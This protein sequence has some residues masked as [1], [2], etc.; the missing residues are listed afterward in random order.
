MKRFF[1]LVSLLLPLSLRAQQAYVGYPS[2][3]GAI[4]IRA[5]FANPPKGYG[6]VPF[7]WWSGDTLRLDRLR[8]ELDILADSPT[9]GFAVSYNHTHAKV[10]TAL[11]ASGYGSCG[12]PEAGKPEAFSEGWW[13]IWNEFSGLCADKGM[14]VGMDD[15]V[16]AWPKNKCYIDDVLSDPELKNYQGK[17][18]KAVLPAGADLP[19]NLVTASAAGDSVIAIYTVC[20]PELHPLYGKKLIDRYFQSFVDHMDEKGLRGM[21]YFFQD[22]LLYK[23]QIDSWCED[24]PEE[25]LKR[26]GYDIVPHLPALFEDMGEESVKTRLDYAEVVTQLAEER[27]FEP[28]YRWHAD[29]G[30]I[31]GC[32]NLG[33]GLDPTRY[34]DY[35][36]AIS[37]FT[38][39]GNDAPA[40][41]SSFIQTKVSSSVAHLYDRP[42]TWLEA[43]HSMGWDANGAVLTHQLDH[44]MIAGGNLL[45]MHG[46]YYSTHG[47]WWEWAPPCFH[48]HM[49]YWEHMKLWLTYA[50]RMC[51]V[52]SQGHHVC[53]IAILYPTE[54]MQALPGTKPD[55][56]FSVADG[57]ST[58][59]YD[60]DFIDFQSLQKADKKDGTISVSG[61]SYRVL[62]LADIQALHEETASAIEAFKAAGGIV[63]S[64]GATCPYLSYEGIT[65][66]GS[67]EVVPFLKGRIVPDFAA[68]AGEARVLHHRVADN[69]VYMVMDVEKGAEMFFRSHGKVEKWDAMDGT[70]SE[71]SAMRTDADG[72][73]VRFDGETGNSRL[74]VFSPGETRIGDDVSESSVILSQTALDGDWN[75]EII[76]TMNNKWGDYRLPASDEYIGVEARSMRYA[77]VP[78][79]FSAELALA[80]SDHE[81]VYGYG[82]YMLAADVPSDAD[83]D[84]LCESEGS[85]ASWEPYEWSWQFG[86]FDSPGSQGY[87]GLKGKVDSRFLILDKGC[88]QLFKTRV[89]APSAGR[90]RLVR[91]GVKPYCIRIDGSDVSEDR[92]K[93]SKG[94]H[95]L[96]VAYASAR[97]TPYSLKG[98]VSSTVDNRDRSMV[99]LYPADAPDAVDCDPYGPV[100]ASR[101]YGTDFLCYNPFGGL[102]GKWAYSFRTAPGTCRMSFG[103]SGQLVSMAVDGRSVRP[104]CETVLRDSS[105]GM[106]DVVVVA[107][108]SDDAPGC[109]FFTDPVKLECSGG[110]MPA[111]DWTEF[112]AMRYFSGGVRYTKTL[113]LDATGGRYVL[114]LGDVDATCEVAVNGKKVKVLLTKPYST[115]ITGYLRNGE[116]TIEVLVYSSLSNHYQTIPSPYK[117]TPRAGLIGPVRLVNYSK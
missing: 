73:W 112:G 17:L 78:E 42:R 45:C 56:A 85:S 86:V 5:G 19:G 14:G 99:M 63:I 76:P 115:D 117:G 43:F 66:L 32:D 98:M 13:K 105:S 8:E 21:N 61:E 87:H 38:A 55:L 12:V 70:I 50:Q 27:Y 91:E 37:W 114:D 103:V 34:M 94:W 92:V 113:S 83:L 24:M 110:R 10:D 64:V 2:R 106:S 7:Y 60:F 79:G 82:P 77:F 28:I 97:R 49:P 96:F 54:T 100:I 47:G 59:G 88:H 67:S 104:D 53:D 9:E 71:I 35:F 46:L 3:D 41:G 44:H 31:Y 109:A 29:R 1:L 90:Y 18:R 25:F 102:K 22:E 84:R 15:Y 111:G 57:L 75:V 116:N 95:T 93:L 107:E 62:L 48:F 74:I 11:N 89:Y 16:F 51:F 81:S 52:L 26:K 23:P 40:R 80:M 36:R 33:R 101:W 4:D 39:P 30:L 68:S 58:S 6:N 108:P 65:S 69:D 72:T 20:S